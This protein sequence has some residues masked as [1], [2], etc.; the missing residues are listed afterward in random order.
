[1]RSKSD[2]RLAYRQQLE[3]AGRYGEGQESEAILGGRRFGERPPARET[4]RYGRTTTAEYEG[5]DYDDGGGRP[6]R[7][8]FRSR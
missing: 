2:H 4:P 3:D 8:R 1:M 5:Y 6:A 7:S